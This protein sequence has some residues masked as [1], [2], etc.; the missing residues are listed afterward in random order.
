MAARHQGRRP[1]TPTRRSI[2]AA[3]S[4]RTLVWVVLAVPAGL[5]LLT[6]LFSSDHR[7]LHDRCAGT[8][9][10]R[11]SRLRRRYARLMRLVAL[12]FATVARRRLRSDRAGHVRF[13]A[14][15]LLWW[16]LP[17]IGRRSAAAIIARLRRRLV[18]RPASPSV[19]S[20]STDPG[21]VVIDEVMGM[22]DHAVPESRSAGA[23]RSSASCCSASFDIVKPYPANGSSVCTAASASWPTMRWRR[24]YANLAL[25]LADAG[26]C[27]DA[28]SSSCRHEGLDHRGRQRDADAVPRRHQLARRSPSG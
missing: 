28:G 11:A 18:E 12:A 24:V 3:P 22:L 27:S 20:A 8:R 9:V 4:L 2:S 23:A 6:A 26:C 25:R 15:L 1:T 10:V 17:R 5:G 7:G 21:P 14:G 16:L 13:A 19:T